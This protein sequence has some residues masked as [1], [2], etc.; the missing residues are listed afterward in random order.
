MRFARYT[1]AIAGIYGIVALV[2]QYFLEKQIGI[3]SAPAITHPEYFY[4][5][6]GVALAFQV[7]F[8]IIARDP[9]RFRPLM[10][11]AVLEKMAFVIPA[12]Y[13]YFNGRAPLQI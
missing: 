4:G 6:I 3:D 1:F 7:V 13:L 10:P 9:V 5:F 11:A 2:P 8:L 12:F